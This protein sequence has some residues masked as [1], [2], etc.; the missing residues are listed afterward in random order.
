MDTPRPTEAHRALTR[1]AGEWSGEE[2]LFPSPWMPEGGSARA[3]IS[4]R[5]ALDG[6]AVISDYEQEVD[7][8]VTYAGHGIWTVEQRTDECVLHWLDSLGMGLETFRGM[9]DGDVVSVVSRNP[10]GYARLTYDLSTDDA[11]RVRMESSED[12][13]EWSPMFEGTYRRHE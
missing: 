13:R 9:W 5:V 7:G 8:A 4:A 3:R 10:M 2:T 1:L 11:L 12:A 6:F